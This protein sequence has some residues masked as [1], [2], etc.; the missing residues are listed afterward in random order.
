MGDGFSLERVRMMAVLSDDPSDD[1]VS[2]LNN[3]ILYTPKDINTY[4]LGKLYCQLGKEY[5]DGDIFEENL[6]KACRFLEIAHSKGSRE[7]RPGDYLMMGMYRL[8]EV[9]EGVR[10][11]LTKNVKLAAKW[12]IEGLKTDIENHDEHWINIM[13]SRIG[14]A[15]LQD[16]I[17]EYEMAHR[18]LTIASVQ[19]HEALFFLAM[20]YDRGIYVE[21]NRLMAADCINRILEAPKEEN[22]VFYDAAE[23]IMACWELDY[24]E[25]I[26]DQVYHSL[27]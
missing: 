11:G 27:D 17:A 18:L 14:R 3:D 1:Y 12:F 23:A 4:D 15:L 8:L 24:P 10:Y 13:F 25:D 5:H 19:E 9:P 7:I 22:D 16:E 6:P 26:I 21:E 20:M 2:P